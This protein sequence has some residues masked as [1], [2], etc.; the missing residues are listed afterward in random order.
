M[1][2]NTKTIDKMMNQLDANDMTM[3]N[4]VSV[5]NWFEKPSMPLPVITYQPMRTLNHELQTM[6]NRQYSLLNDVLYN[7]IYRQ[8]KETQLKYFVPIKGIVDRLK[9]LNTRVKTSP[10]QVEMLELF[11]HIVWG[12]K[13][14]VMTDSGCGRSTMQLLYADTPPIK[15]LTQ[16][17]RE[18][19]GA[20]E[21][22]IPHFL[23]LWSDYISSPLT[24]QAKPK[25]TATEGE[26]I[27]IADRA[28][29]KALINTNYGRSTKAENPN[30]APVADSPCIIVLMPGGRELRV[31]I[32]EYEEIENYKEVM[33]KYYTAV[34][35]PESKITFRVF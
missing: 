3:I 4:L 25:R 29:T 15:S 13:Y 14:V 10:H 7:G 11:T 2:Y 22:N 28:V 18:V 30:D 34:D 24:Q 17:C 26:I 1:K 8:D 6:A 21:I 5:L 27:A 35:L 19:R 9:N 33:E 23:K 31:N 12:E 16:V 20:G 32:P